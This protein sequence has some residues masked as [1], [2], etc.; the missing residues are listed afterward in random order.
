MLG[1]RFSFFF[2][3][4]IKV[5]SL[6]VEIDVAVTMLD[7]DGVGVGGERQGAHGFKKRGKLALR[8]RTIV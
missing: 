2:T 8:E 1:Q 3:G 4:G 6:P 5:D 7:G